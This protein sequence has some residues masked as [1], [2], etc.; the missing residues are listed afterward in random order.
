MR[1]IDFGMIEPVVELPI[2][3]AFYREKQVVELEK[4]IGKIS[5]DYIIPYPP[6]IP[7]VIPGE[8]ITYEIYKEV[9]NLSQN[10]VEIIGPLDYNRGK[11]RL[12][13]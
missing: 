5:A 1:Q 4:A 10:G 6:G 8:V 3:E 13:K 12:V 9:L 11:I 2:G 7:I